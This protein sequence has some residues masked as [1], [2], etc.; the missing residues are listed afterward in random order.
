MKPVC[1]IRRESAKNNWWVIFEFWILVTEYPVLR[2]RVADIHVS[3]LS[4]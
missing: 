3:H 1:T 4:S 2:F